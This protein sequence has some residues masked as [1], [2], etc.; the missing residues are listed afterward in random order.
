[1][2]EMPKDVAIKSNDSR[3]EVTIKELGINDKILDIGSVTIDNYSRIIRSSGTIFMS[4]PPGMFED[5]R[6]SKG[7]EELLRAM[8]SSLGTTIVSGGHLSAAL[9][10]IGRKELIDHVSTAGGAL[11]LFLAGKK[12]PL[13]EVLDKAARKKIK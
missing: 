10:R 6:F 13:F 7:T 1:V 4:G 12:L 5:N 2:F 3:A 11:V 8:T 9:E